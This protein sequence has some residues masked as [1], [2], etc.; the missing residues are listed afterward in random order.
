MTHKIILLNGPPSS[1]KD[2]ASKIIRYKCGAR[3]YK[4]SR[5]LKIGLCEFFQFD[6]SHAID[7]LEPN[8]DKQVEPL[9]RT[10]DGGQM[11]VMTWRQVQISLS[12]TW[13]KPLFGDDIIGRL[14]V[15]YLC[16]PTSFSLTVISDCGFRHEMIPLIKQ[17]GADNLFLIQLTRDGCTY[18]GDSRSYVELDDL[19]VTTVLLDNRYPLKPTDK[20]PLTFEMQIVS[21]VNGW[22][23]VEEDD[24]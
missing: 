17:F 23:G 22:L 12:E 2:T 21:A 10:A 8:K 4:M 16:K 6:V 9:F 5:P 18:E 15:S 24:D 19:G 3:K 13:A 20:M 7:Q 14:A 1:G 11:D